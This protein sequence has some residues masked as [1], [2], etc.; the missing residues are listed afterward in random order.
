MTRRALPAAFLLGS[1][2]VLGVLAVRAPYATAVF[3]VML[4]GPLHVLLALR[5]LTG[6]VSGAVPASVGW[7]LAAIVAVMV[8]LRAVTAL[9]PHLGHLL[10]AV[11]SMTLVA[12]ALVRGLRGR[13]RF[14]AVVPVALIAVVSAMQLPWYWHL[15]SH[16]H[17]LIPLIFL[18]DWARRF[19]RNGR[20]AFVAV[21]LVW[22]AAVPA[23]LLSGVMDPLVND[24]PPGTVTAL[25]DPA[26]VAAAAAPP[27]VDGV[28]GTRF[29]AVFAFLQMM[30]YALWMVFF[31]AWGRTE[32]RRAPLLTGPRF[33]VLAG[34]LSAAIWLVYAADYAE[35]RA[36]YALLGVLNLYLEQPIAVWLLLTALPATAT[37]ALVGRLRGSR[38]ST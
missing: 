9:A 16:A 29:L 8:P 15:F 38:R 12:F 33:W 2:L 14:L 28:L 3:G 5:Y 11:G 22:A 17:N 19:S 31:Q 25:V 20:I 1:A 32:T 21:N 7:A 6:R 18:W 10:E 34:A 27:G 13:M 30:H 37:S 23:L 26:V 35:G 24:V 36:V 4:L